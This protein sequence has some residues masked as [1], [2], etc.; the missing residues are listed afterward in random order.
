MA[1]AGQCLVERAE[2]LLQC[3]ILPVR[4]PCARF[5]VTMPLGKGTKLG[6]KLGKIGADRHNVADA[7]QCRLTLAET[8]LRY[9]ILSVRFVPKLTILIGPYVQTKLFKKGIIICLKG[10]PCKI[11]FYV[12]LEQKHVTQGNLLIHTNDRAGNGC[13][14]KEYEYEYEY[15][16]DLLMWTGNGLHINIFYAHDLWADRKQTIIVYF[17]NTSCKYNSKIQKT[18]QM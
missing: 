9:C 7:G 3:C 15:E 4:S 16:S 17:K 11:L 5:T 10:Y 6:K 1:Y 12:V 13:C 2:I 14:D 8:L 18:R